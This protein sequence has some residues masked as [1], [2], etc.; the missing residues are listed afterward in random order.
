MTELSDVSRFITGLRNSGIAVRAGVV[1][2]TATA[3]IVQ[4]LTDDSIESSL[5]HLSPGGGSTLY[6]ALFL[7]TSIA[8]QCP[9]SSR[10][11]IL[12]VSDGEDNLSNAT[13]DEVVQAAVRSVSPI[14]ALSLGEPARQYAPMSGR[15]DQ[16]LRFVSA[17]SG[18]LA[19]FPKNQAQVTEALAAIRSEMQKQYFATV[20][21][22]KGHHKLRFKTSIP[23][24]VIRGISAITVN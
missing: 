5:E 22:T 1:E 20:S 16:F 24:G 15:G 7:A 13:P 17:Q 9:A 10:R 19:Y 8:Q 21:T 3:R 14:Y 12:L 11:L 4:N 23:H 2:F 6:D 18:G